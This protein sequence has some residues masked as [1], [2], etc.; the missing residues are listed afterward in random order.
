M[1]ICAILLLSSL[2]IPSF[3]PSFRAN[4]HSVS[5]PQILAIDENN[6]P[7]SE[8]KPGENERGGERRETSFLTSQVE[9]GQETDPATTESKPNDDGDGR[10]SGRVNSV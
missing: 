6:R 10:G 5:E 2:L 8:T 7:E 4:F 1:R 3:V 9:E